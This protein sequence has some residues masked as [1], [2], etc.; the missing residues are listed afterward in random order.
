[1][2]SKSIP[3]AEDVKQSNV[4]LWKIFSAYFLVGLT[5]FSMAIL[6]K[7]KSLVMH[8]KWVSEEEMNEGLALVQMYPGPLMVDFTAYV[9]Y[10]LRGVP[11][12]VLATLGFIIPSF[13]M[14]IGLSFLY[15]AAADLSW[16]HL[17]FSGLEALVIGVIFNVTLDMG[18]RTLKGRVE[19]VIA[20]L[21]FTALLLKVNAI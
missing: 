8:N 10:K 2:D 19:A 20:L 18:S 9:G 3:E 14:M 11:G 17:V 21:A 15:F 5:A 12:A 6:Q 1:M 13:L 16:A 7:L 4:S